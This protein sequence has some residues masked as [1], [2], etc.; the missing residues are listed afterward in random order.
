MTESSEVKLHF[1][2]YWRVIKLRLGLILLTFF[3]VVATAGVYVYFLPRQF[4]SQ[5]TLEVKPDTGYRTTDI[6]AAFASGRTDPQFLATQIQLL[7]KSEILHPVIEKLDLTTQLSPPGTKMPIQWVTE[8]LAKS[9]VVQEQRNTT[10]VEVGVYH[11]DKELAARIKDVAHRDSGHTE[12]VR[13]A[14]GI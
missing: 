3:L 12:S 9:M 13:Y 6:Q 2:D 8:V 10:L 1:L 5:V 11:T 7:K 4:Y 14:G